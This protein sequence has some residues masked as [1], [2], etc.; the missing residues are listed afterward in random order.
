MKILLARHAARKQDSWRQGVEI[1]RTVCPASPQK[2]PAPPLSGPPPTSPSHRRE[3][4]LLTVL[5]GVLF[6]SMAVIPPLMDPLVRQ[7]FGLTKSASSRFLEA[8]T[9]AT[10]VFSLLAGVLSDRWGRRLPLAALAVAGN[11]ILLGLLPWI[12]S[13]PLLLVLRFVQGA[14][15]ST[16]QVLLLTRALDLSTPS[17]RGRVLGIV[18]IALPAAYLLG[19]ALIALAGDHWRL[20]LALIGSA[21]VLGGLLLLPWIARE[22]PAEVHRAEATPLREQLTL[23]F[24]SRPLLAPLFFGMAE[25]FTFGAFAAL[26]SFLILDVHG[27][28]GTAP[29]ALAT[30]LFFA[31]FLCGLYPAG[32]LID[33]FGPLPPLVASGVLYALAVGSLGLVPWSGFLA[34]MAVAGALA[35]LMYPA[36]IALV[37]SAVPAQDRGHAFGLFNTTGTIGMLAGLITCSHLSES[38]FVHAYLAAGAVQAAAAVLVL[39]VPSKGAPRA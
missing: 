9:L 36:S 22:Q 10:L 1:L 15:D 20:L 26:T 13:W 11:G 14:C 30:G 25:K 2:A 28:Q 12:Q 27:L 35:A 3:I 7:P 19:P 29:I 23:L 21:G 34:L 4:L 32:R 17:T 16:A 38:S 18:T 8:N 24:R 6:L 39:L 37:A 33:R 31:L 5:Q